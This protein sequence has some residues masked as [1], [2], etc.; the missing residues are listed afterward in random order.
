MFAFI[1]F[2]SSLLKGIQ[3]TCAIHTQ[4]N[5]Q[6]SLARMLFA[7]FFWSFLYFKKQKTI[8]RQIKEY[9]TKLATTPN[10]Y[11]DS[12]NNTNTTPTAPHYKTKIKIIHYR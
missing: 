10:T 3:D 1:G 2:L 6:A 4:V 8:R 5:R 7:I 11:D 9:N 12:Q